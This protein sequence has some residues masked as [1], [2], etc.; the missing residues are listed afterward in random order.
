MT[1]MTKR[2]L[3]TAITL[4]L[5]FIIIYFMPYYSYAAFSALAVLTAIAASIEMRGLFEKGGRWPHLSPAL[6]L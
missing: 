6:F 5:L 1:S 3:T 4:P 2:V